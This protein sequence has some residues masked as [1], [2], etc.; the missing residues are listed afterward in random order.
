MS[1]ARGDADPSPARHAPGG[2]PP[3]HVDAPPP[4]QPT[5]VVDVDGVDVA[6]TAIVVEGSPT[7][8]ELRGSLATLLL[9]HGDA[10][11]R[12]AR[13]EL[14]HAV[15]AASSPI[16]VVARAEARARAVVERSG[17]AGQGVGNG[18]VA[19]ALLG[20]AGAPVWLLARPSQVMRAELDSCAML[21]GACMMMVALA[22]LASA[23]L[24]RDAHGEP[25]S[26]TTL[27]LGAVVA[28]G[29]LATSTLGAVVHRAIVLDAWSPTVVAGIGLQLAGIACAAVAL[30]AAFAP[31]RLAGAAAHGA[32]G[33]VLATPSVRLRALADRFAERVDGLD[34]RG[35]RTLDEAIDAEVARLVASG[36]LPAETAASMRSIDVRSVPFDAHL[37]ARLAVHPG[38]TVVLRPHL[39]SEVVAM[40][41]DGGSNG[42][43]L[44][45]RIVAAASGRRSRPGTP[46]EV[47]MLVDLVAAARV[48]VLPHD[49]PL[50]VVAAYGRTAALAIAALAIA[51]T[52]PMLAGWQQIAADVARAA[53]P[54][55]P[56]GLVATA[57]ALL[58]VADVVERRGRLRSLPITVAW[59]LAAVAATVVALVVAAAT[60]YSPYLVELRA[61]WA[62]AAALLAVLAASPLALRVV[63]R[64]RGRPHD[65]VHWRSVPLPLTRARVAAL[66]RRRARAIEEAST[67]HVDELVILLRPA[68]ALAVDIAALD[69]RVLATLPPVRAGGRGARA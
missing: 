48:P 2:A 62:R 3:P 50:A 18:I 16:G 14:A 41:L 36:A 34:A 23:R 30:V 26:G 68:I 51:V 44:V 29:T 4:T 19:G 6:A 24:G 60:P 55:A 61:P 46:W 20:M 57:V 59:G 40:V 7:P 67:A 39:T 47:G 12:R 28:I 65:P 45:R 64:L 69:A 43:R 42:A 8:A 38:T 21:A 32:A 37:A 58:L 22:V 13:A 9:G 49:R 31:Q 33:I 35:A 1:A 63:E 66:E 27:E 10:D 11:V 54:A 5:V 52:V 56:V 15:A 17:R 25:R 53:A